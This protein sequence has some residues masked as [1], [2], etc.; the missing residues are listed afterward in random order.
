RGDV[1]PLVAFALELRALGHD[2]RMCVPPDFRAWIERLGVPVTPLGPELRWT[3]R[4]AVTGSLREMIE[5]TVATQFE[6][7]A[8][9]ARGCDAIVGASALQV[10]APPVAE[11]LRHPYVVVAYCP[12][13]LPSLHHAPPV[14]PPAPPAAGADH[15]TQWEA[16]A[17][18]WNAMWGAAIDARRRALG[19][20]PVSDVRSYVLTPQ[21]WLAAD[22]A[23]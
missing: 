2:V 20:A 11:S 10:A 5:G 12:A 19:L 4:T 21:P 3:G 1:Q 23:L 13:V 9:A 18:R 22:P 7:I 6:T 8:A 16:D 14:L 17:A 15:R